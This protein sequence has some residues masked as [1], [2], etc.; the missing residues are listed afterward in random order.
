M[1][2]MAPRTWVDTDEFIRGVAD[3]FRELDDAG[4]RAAV[5]Q[6]AADNRRIHDRECINLNPATN[7]MNPDAEALLASGLGS[8]PSLG[9]PGNKYE[10]GLEAIERLE[11]Y[12]AELA[13]M[14][15]GARYAEIRVASGAMANL[16]AF[17]ACCRPGDRIIV[18]PPEIGGHVTHQAAGAAGLFGLEIHY[19]P[20][21]A[22]RYTVDAQALAAMMERLRPAL[23]TLGGSLNIR[24]HPVAEVAGAAHR[25]GARLLFDAAHLSGPIAGGAWPNP[26]AEG[27][28]LVTM[29]TY[30]SLG[31]PPAGLILC[32]DAKLARRMEEIAF[33]GLTAN[34]DVA[35][36]AALAITLLDWLRHGRAYAAAMVATADA[37]V[38]ALA[39]SGM[40][41][42]GA[43]AGGVWQSHQLAVEAAPFGGGQ[44]ASRLLREANVLACGIGLPL[45]AVEGDLNGLR[46][47]TP[48]CVRRGMGEDHMETIAGFVADCLAGRRPAIEI[49]A[50]VTEF[51]AGF[52]GFRYLG[53]SDSANS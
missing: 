19:A 10:M 47:G 27:A 49:A 42:F 8:R 11:V 24:H 53:G 2:A 30:K 7:V 52:T 25:H 35:K 1:I 32:N 45:D 22:D 23:V 20:V 50:E 6:A 18:Q 17:M 16:Y 51:R 46:L 41:V 5:Q 28:D 33:P 4:M 13:C 44:A 36:S 12:A 31:G 34:F 37:L 9:Y 29:S 43:A 48:E 26:L 3:A 14:V 39:E 21:D 15:F 38:K 40:P